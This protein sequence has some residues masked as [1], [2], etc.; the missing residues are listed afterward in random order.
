MDLMTDHTTASNQIVSLISGQTDDERILFLNRPDKLNA[1]NSDV[2]S[3]IESFVTQL[4]SHPPTVLRIQTAGTKAFVAG[5]DIANMAT[6]TPPQALEFARKGASVFERISRLRSVV[7]A[8]I[9]GFALGGGLELALSADVLY[10]LDSAKFGLP[11][12]GLGLIPGFGGTQRLSRRIGYGNAIEWTCSGRMMSAQEALS[13][14]LVNRVTA[15][16]E[17]LRN[18]VNQLVADILSK[19]P[20]AV[21]NAKRAIQASLEVPMSSGLEMEAQLF[22]ECF[23]RA[24]SKEGIQAFLEKRKAVFS[25]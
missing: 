20:L 21:R 17:E 1:L 15:T 16:P 25:R 5:A 10:A 23:T 19:G 13:F 12:V 4:E 18:Q 14:G 11:E 22:S 2:L 8:E 7:I 6:L 9:Q 3:A 24:E